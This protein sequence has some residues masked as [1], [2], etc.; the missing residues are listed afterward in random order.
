MFPVVS[1]RIPVM[2]ENAELP[3]EIDVQQVKDLLDKQV[4]FLFLDCREPDEHQFCRVEQAQLIPLR[5]IP[6]KKQVFLEQAEQRVVVMC[7]HG[8]RSMNAAQWLR[9]NGITN[10]QSMAGGIEEWSLRID[11]SVPR[12]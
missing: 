7:H 9:A 12:Y 8:V 10:V 5:Q 3:I 2:N 6:G 1:A 11:P 4:D